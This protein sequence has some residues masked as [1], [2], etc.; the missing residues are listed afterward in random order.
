MHLCVKNNDCDLLLLFEVAKVD[1][2]IVAQYI[3]ERFESMEIGVRLKFLLLIRQLGAW[4]W[5][6]ELI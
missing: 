6:T 5:N 2:A 4:Y 1:H 3:E